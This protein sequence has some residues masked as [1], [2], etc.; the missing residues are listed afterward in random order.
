MEPLDA[1]VEVPT[2]HGYHGLQR[3]VFYETAQIS[4]ATPYIS[5][6]TAWI[7]DKIAQIS[8][9]TLKIKGNKRKID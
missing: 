1:S 5:R 8:V 6:R 9:K 4:H 7:S 2:G 3:I